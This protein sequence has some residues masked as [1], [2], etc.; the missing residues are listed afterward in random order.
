MP[1]FAAFPGWSRLV[2]GRGQGRSVQVR[3]GRQQ[4]WQE[5]AAEC[6]QS[7]A[8]AALA[9]SRAADF[10]KSGRGRHADCACSGA[11]KTPAA[12]ALGCSSR[13]TSSDQISP[14]DLSHANAFSHLHS[15]IACALREVPV[16]F[17][18]LAPCPLC[19]VL[20]QKRPVVVRPAIWFGSLIYPAPRLHKPCASIYSYRAFVKTALR[21]FQ[22]LAA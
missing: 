3:L 1:L 21:P 9:G 7:C 17:A 4:R 6:Q 13:M 11:G 10:R 14:G 8:L 12:G 18:C 2:F 5:E 15:S 20:S 19:L 22:V 16:C